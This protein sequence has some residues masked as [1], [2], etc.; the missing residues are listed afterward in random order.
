MHKRFHGHMAYSFQVV[1]CSFYIGYDVRI[2]QKNSDHIIERQKM[3]QP[4]KSHIL[5]LAQANQENGVFMRSPTNEI[6][7][8]GR[9]ISLVKYDNSYKNCKKKQVFEI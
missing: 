6:P 1:R 9:G 7:L 3:A 5:T 2:L 8:P 4:I